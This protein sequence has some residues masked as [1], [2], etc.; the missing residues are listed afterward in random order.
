[1]ILFILFLCLA[2]L[3]TLVLLIINCFNKDK[4]INNNTIIPKIIYQT[5]FTKDI[6]NEI[7]EYTNKMLKKNP[8]YKYYLY[9]DVDMDNFVK[10]N[11]DI[12]TYT[13]FKKLK[14]PTAKAD[15]WRY[16][17]LYKTGGIYLDMDSTIDIDLDNFINKNDYAILSKEKNKDIFIQWCLIFNKNHPILKEV[18]NLVNYN[19]DNKLYENDILNLTGPKVFTKGLHNIHNKYFNYPL[20]WNSNDKDKIYIIPN[21]NYRIYGFDFNNKINF[22]DIKLN[23]LLNKHKKQ[24]KLKYW[25]NE[26]KF[27]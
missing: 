15:F 21:F 23:N 12:K 9:D 16:L 2:L 27:L 13:N 19:I 5:W 3:T 8:N 11:Y 7:L 20:M 17:I 10:N 14:V 22:K 1:M 25:K 24:N 18:I 26:K 4:F 6:P